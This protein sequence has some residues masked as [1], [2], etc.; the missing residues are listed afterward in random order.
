MRDRNGDAPAPGPI[1]NRLP[2][3]FR[4]STNAHGRR[5]NK[6]DHSALSV[7]TLKHRRAVSSGLPLIL[8][9]RLPE[10]M[11]ELISLREKVAQAEL[12][13]GGYAVNGNGHAVRDKRPDP[14]SAG[15]PRKQSK[16]RQSGT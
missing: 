15:K 7:M 14:V 9:D 13:A 2:Q 12:A 8:E 10:L 4:V 5:R 6:R 16:L 3:L 1:I 11:S